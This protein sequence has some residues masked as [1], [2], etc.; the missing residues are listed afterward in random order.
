MRVP[1]L[2]RT[3]GLYI[4]TREGNPCRTADDLD[5]AML[6]TRQF[7]FEGPVMH[8]THW[9]SALDAYA[10]SACWPAFPPPDQ[11]TFLSTLLHTKDSSPGPDGTPYAAI[12]M[13]SYLCDILNGSALPPVQIGVW[14][15]KAI[16]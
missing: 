8:D 4:L 5:A 11:A 16:S 9:D 12:A 1:A 13:D 10:S 14:I 3:M 7:W 15:P 2:P 6:A